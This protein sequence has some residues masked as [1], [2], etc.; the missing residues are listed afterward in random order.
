MRIT[1][2]SP[3][4][5]ISAYTVRLLSAYVKN[6][7]FK[8]SL[9][10]LPDLEFELKASSD[11]VYQYSDLTIR[12]VIDICQESDLIGISLLSCYFDRVVQ[13]TGALK[14][15]LNVPVIWGGKHPSAKPEEALE[16]ADIVCIGEGED[17]LAELMQKMESNRDYLNTK[18]F[19]F[20][21]KKRIIKNPIGPLIENLDDIPL[22]D[23]SFEDHYVWDKRLNKLIELDVGTFRKFLEVGRYSSLAEY[24]T[25]W[26]RGCPYSCTYCFSFR[27]MYRGQKYV[28]FRSIKNLIEELE[29]ARDKLDCAGMVHL[30]DDNIFIQTVDTIKE[31]CEIY[32]EKIN[33]PLRFT[34]HPKD[35]SEEKLSYF[36][37]AGLSDIHMGVQT[38]S[39]K[40][41]KLY[42]RH[43]SNETVLRAAYAINKFKHSL[44]ATYDIIVDNPYETNEDTIQTLKLI[45]KFPRPYH[46][47]IF[48]LA[49]FPGTKLYKKAK[50]DKLFLPEEESKLY[51]K[52][53][54]GVQFQEKRYLN[55][56]LSLMNVSVPYFVIKFLIDRRVVRLLDRNAINRCIFKIACFLKRVRKS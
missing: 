54:L 43:I 9:I 40:T 22:P 51:R 27:N 26:S 34:G 37:K 32:R 24:V 48:N 20:K 14:T 6:R 41:K 3:S 19:W 42:N 28:R 16:Y 18:G 23:Y 10:F 45:L 8:S 30:A 29:I 13:L 17:A 12:Q 7:G 39:K 44:R 46:L 53:I 5:D 36:I 38:G 2:I 11:M 35:I 52:P 55:Y 31:F 1:L 50:E 49:L 4:S 47:C 33:L 25:M 21:Y 15:E 56:V